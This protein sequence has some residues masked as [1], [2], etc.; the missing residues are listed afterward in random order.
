MCIFSK[1]PF[2]LFTTFAT[3]K[4][5]EHYAFCLL[6]NEHYSTDVEN[7]KSHFGHFTILRFILLQAKYICNLWYLRLFGISSQIQFLAWESVWQ[8]TACQN[9]Q[10]IINTQLNRCFQCQIKL[11]FNSLENI[12]FYCSRSNLKDH[13]TWKL[14]KKKHSC[15]NYQDAANRIYLFFVPDPPPL[16]ITYAYII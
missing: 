15:L 14:K 1:L 5:T 6:Q 3:Y 11:A 7:L 13:Y 10:E 4:C 8:V 16:H 12:H 2:I 9:L